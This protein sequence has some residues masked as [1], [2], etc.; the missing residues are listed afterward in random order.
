V[1]HV[2]HELAH[3]LLTLFYTYEL[4]TLFVMTLLEEAGI[5]IPIPSDTLVALAGSQRSVPFLHSVAAIG[6]ASLAAFLGSS[7]LF[8]VM[9]RGGR[10]LLAR[11]GH[12]LRLKQSHIE[13]MENAF[14]KHGRWILIVGRLIPGLRIVATIIAGISGMSYPDF[15]VTVIIA[16]VIWAT[17]YYTLGSI[18]EREIPVVLAFFRNFVTKSPSWAVALVGVML[19]TAII[20]VAC[21]LIWRWRRKRAGEAV[22]ELPASA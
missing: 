20:L 11:Y 18:V 12:L 21:W 14:A 5:P 6:L 9:K 19:V 4:P 22:P 15:A 17:F 2:I 1:F 13:M 3:T 7:V 16:A 10:P 8:L